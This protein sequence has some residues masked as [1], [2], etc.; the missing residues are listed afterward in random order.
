MAAGPQRFSKGEKAFHRNR[1]PLSVGFGIEK[2]HAQT[3]Q[4][5]TTIYRSDGGLPLFAR[6][7]EAMLMSGIWHGCRAVLRNLGAQPH[8]IR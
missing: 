6:P 2:G 1:W 7:R 3:K 5:R 4:R 8:A